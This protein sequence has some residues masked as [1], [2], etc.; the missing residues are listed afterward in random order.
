MDRLC[1]RGGKEGVKHILGICVQQTEENRLQ[2]K[3]HHVVPMTAF[4]MPS[5]QRPHLRH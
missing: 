4:N 2:S 1:R 3:K 5:C